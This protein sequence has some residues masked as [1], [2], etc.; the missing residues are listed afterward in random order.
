MAQT[1]ELTM[2]EVQVLFIAAG[3]INPDDVLDVPDGPLLKELIHRSI[4][5]RLYQ[6]RT[7]DLTFLLRVK[8][9]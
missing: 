2:D 9:E 8:D 1:V 6:E 7:G 3:S 4:A 5:A